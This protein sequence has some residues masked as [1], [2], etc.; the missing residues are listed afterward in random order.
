MKAS[1]TDFC[2][3]VPFE[4]KC[5][6]LI[7]YNHQKIDSALSISVH[8]LW[9]LSSPPTFS[10]NT[11][12]LYAVTTR[13]QLQQTR[14]FSVTAASRTPCHETDVGCGSSYDRDVL[15]A[16][17]V[18]RHD[19]KQV[20]CVWYSYKQETKSLWCHRQALWTVAE[21]GYK[22]VDVGADGGYHLGEYVS[23]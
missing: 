18:S 19:K 13:Q 1:T 5:M 20:I 4:L 2:T 15:R 12:R 7:K 23:W 6:Y 3:Q 16:N 14:C 10:S 9:E 17:M 8:Y 21:L 11:A 22:L